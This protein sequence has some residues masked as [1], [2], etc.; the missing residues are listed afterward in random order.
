MVLFYKLT[1]IFT[2]IHSFHIFHSHLKL[3]SLFITWFLKTV[4]NKSHNMKALVTLNHSWSPFLPLICS[5]GK[6]MNFCGFLCGLLEYFHD[7]KT[8][9][10]SPCKS[11]N[12]DH[13]WADLVMAW[14]SL[15]KR[16]QEH[17]VVKLMWEFDCYYFVQDMP[18]SSH[19]S[20]YK[21]TWSKKIYYTI[22]SCSYKDSIV[23]RNFYKLILI[24]YNKSWWKWCT[25]TN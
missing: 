5:Y 7:K 4:H 18:V 20:G 22:P 11:H 25:M 24:W 10:R 2:N 15:D 12:H 8:P 17:K 14:L 9:P 21:Q 19:D 23:M 3:P 13:Q 6:N 1:F 16:I